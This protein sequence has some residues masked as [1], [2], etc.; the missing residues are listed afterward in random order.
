[1]TYL[2]VTFDTQ[3]KATAVHVSGSADKALPEKG[4]TPDQVFDNAARVSWQYINQ[5]I[6]PSGHYTLVFQNPKSL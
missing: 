4:N 3:N 2:L 1:M 5:I 6:H